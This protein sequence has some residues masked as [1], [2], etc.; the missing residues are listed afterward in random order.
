MV[1]TFSFFVEEKSPI[2]AKTAHDIKIN[3]ILFDFLGFKFFFFS[4]I[5]GELNKLKVCVY[6]YSCH[7]SWFLNKMMIFPM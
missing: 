7:I 1:L 6:I 5:L 3:M 4:E 2:L